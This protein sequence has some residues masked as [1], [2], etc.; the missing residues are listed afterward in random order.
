MST[1]VLTDEGLRAVAQTVN[2]VGQLV[3]D[4]EQRAF[5]RQDARRQKGEPA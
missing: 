5:V 2:V 4:P 3:Y 1:Y